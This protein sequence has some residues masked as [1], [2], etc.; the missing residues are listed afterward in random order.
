VLAGAG[1]PLAGAGVPLAGAAG[2]AAFSPGAPINERM[3][4]F[5]T[6]PEMPVPWMRLMSTLCS[7]AIFLTSGEDRC[8]ASSS[9]A[10]DDVSASASTVGGFGSEGRAGADVAAAG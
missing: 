7:F 4:F 3:S 10:P 2:A 8:R 6:R 5:V 9:V 1:V